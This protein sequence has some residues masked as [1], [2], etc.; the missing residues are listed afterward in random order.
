MTGDRRGGPTGP[1]PTT[2]PR[3]ART[4]TQSEIEAMSEDEVQALLDQAERERLLIVTDGGER[5]VALPVAEYAA[6]VGSELGQGAGSSAG[7]DD[8]A[9]P[10]DLAQGVAEAIRDSTDR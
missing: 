9:A 2:D 5:V 1:S 3:F 7:P 4:V 10:R 6:L 8:G